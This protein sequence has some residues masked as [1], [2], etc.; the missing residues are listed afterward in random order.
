VGERKLPKAF[1]TA[2]ERS[3]S[4]RSDDQPRR[5]RSDPCFLSRIKAPPLREA[6][7]AADQRPARKPQR[8]TEKERTSDVMAFDV[9]GPG[10]IMPPV[11][12]R[13]KRCD[14]F[15]VTFSDQSV[16]NGAEQGV[17]RSRRGRQSAAFCWSSPGL[18]GLAAGASPAY[19]V[20]NGARSRRRSRAVIDIPDEGTAPL[21]AAKLRL[22]APRDA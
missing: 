21:K 9:K 10:N 2:A 4:S 15:R 17:E 18:I 8:M 12:N 5:G 1:P 3:S 22:P 20:G 7:R 11:L 19:S 16:A 14:S 13:E 6:G